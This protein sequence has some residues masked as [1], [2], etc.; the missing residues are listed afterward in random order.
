MNVIV[1]WDKINQ[2]FTTFQYNKNKKQ[3]GREI[4]RKKVR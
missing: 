4:M 2:S 1:G 3:T